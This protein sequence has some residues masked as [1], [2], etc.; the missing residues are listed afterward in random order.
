MIYFII[1][2]IPVLGMIWYINFTFWL[3]NKDDPN[4][5][6]IAYRQHILGAL[7]TFIIL[8]LFMFTTLIIF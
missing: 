2:S 5:K 7:L 8:F 3:K 1:F 4:K 6:L